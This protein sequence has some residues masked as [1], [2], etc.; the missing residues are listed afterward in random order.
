GHAGL[1]ENA[2]DVRLD[3]VEREAGASRDLCVR[4]PL[5]QF[6]ENAPLRRREDVGVWRAPSAVPSLPVHA[7]MLW[8][9]RG[10]YLTRS[11]GSPSTGSGR[12]GETDATLYS[13]WR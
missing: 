3:R 6:I 5:A 1:R 12:T 7:P 9:A 2:R 11:H 13:P 8:R 4:V 10:N